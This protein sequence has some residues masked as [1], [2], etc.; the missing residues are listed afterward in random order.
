MQI[1]NNTQNEIYYGIS[2]SS[3]FDCGTIEAQ[4]TTELSGW[5]NTDNVTLNFSALPPEPSGVT[6]FT[7]TI[8]ESK[9]GMAVTI[10][11]YHE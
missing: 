4:Q 7:V 5:D 9:T 10:G 3:S 8:P 6:P 1:F 2:T 11:L